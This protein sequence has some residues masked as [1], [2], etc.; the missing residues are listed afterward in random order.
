MFKSGADFQWE[1]ATHT[2]TYPRPTSDEGWTA[3]LLH[4]IAHAELQHQH[5]SRDI[6]LLGKERDAWQHAVKK[7]APT[8]DVSITP[9]I[10]EEAMDSYRDWLHARSTCPVCQA[11]GMETTKHVY[12]CPACRHQWQV[13]EARICGL[14]RYGIQK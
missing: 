11:V 14:R 7:L 1:D 4:E 6:E 13:N 12:A 3:Q 2:I 10:V 9:Q 5:Y 8:Y